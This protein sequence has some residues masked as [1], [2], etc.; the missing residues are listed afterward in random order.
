MITAL[1]ELPCYYSTGEEIRCQRSATF[2]RYSNLLEPL[3]TMAVQYNRYTSLYLSW[4][5]KVIIHNL[6]F[7]Y[8]LNI[9]FS[10]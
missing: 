6:L 5:L 8:E 4:K 2:I 3:N 10:I 9:Y 1:S 7:N